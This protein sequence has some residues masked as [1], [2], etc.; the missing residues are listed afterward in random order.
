MLRLIEHERFA[1]GAAPSFRNQKTRSVAEKAGFTLTEL[2]CVI[3]IIAICIIL[4]IPSIK[5]IRS[6]SDIIRCSENIQQSGLGLKLYASEH[7]GRLPSD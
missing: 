4:L 3:V 7:Q 6:K 2:A 1:K 5:D